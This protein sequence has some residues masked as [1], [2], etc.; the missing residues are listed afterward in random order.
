MWE[1]SKRLKRSKCKAKEALRT[2]RV[3][4]PVPGVMGVPWGSEGAP[5]LQQ[6]TWSSNWYLEEEYQFT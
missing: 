3:T 5:S 2:C 6:G 4:S 1:G